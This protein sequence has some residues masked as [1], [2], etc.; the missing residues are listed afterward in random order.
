VI[1]QCVALLAVTAM[2]GSLH[3]DS[4]YD[5]WLRYASLE[6]ARQTQYSALPATIVVLGNSSLTRSAADE[7]ARGLQGMLGRVPRTTT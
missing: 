3:A 6:P 7:L 2:A 1:R 4:G 5:G